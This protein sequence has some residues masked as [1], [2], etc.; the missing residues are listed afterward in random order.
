MIA[1][2]TTSTMTM[3]KMIAPGNYPL[4]APSAGPLGPRSLLR[5]IPAPRR[6]LMPKPYPH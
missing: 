1:T 4:P 2:G 6:S 5:G 3:T